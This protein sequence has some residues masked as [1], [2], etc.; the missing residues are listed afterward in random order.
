VTPEECRR[1]AAAF[2]DMGRRYPAMAYRC[3]QLAR[4]WLAEAELLEA[5][6]RRTPDLPNDGTP[7]EPR[8]DPS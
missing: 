3:A 8:Q 4:G 1:K 7:K 6:A 5:E 2:L